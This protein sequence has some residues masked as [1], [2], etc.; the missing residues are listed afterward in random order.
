MRL[1][2]TAICLSTALLTGIVLATTFA[3]DGWSK[4]ERDT[5]ATLHLSQLPP[6]PA[7]PSNRVETMPR[8][9]ELGKRLFFDP[10]LSSNGKVSCA[11]CHDPKQ[12]FQDGKPVGQGVGTGIRRTMQVVGAGHSAFLF[13]DGRKDSL[14]AQAVGPL[15]D[16]AEHGGNRLAYARLMQQHYRSDYEAVFGALPDLQRLP[17]HA[18]PV[19]TPAQRAAW[20]SLDKRSQEDV[21]RVLANI[22]KAIAAYEKI[23]YF[24]ESRLDQYIDGVLKNDRQADQ[25]LTPSEKNGLRLFIGA[26]RCV[27]CH[28]GPLLSD[29]HFHNTGNAPHGPMPQILGRR[30]GVTTV[31]A[32]EFNCLGRFSDA[33]P[34]QC[35]ELNFLMA[36]GPALDGAFKTPSLRNV[37]LRPPYMHAGQM[38]TLSDVVRHYRAAPAAK[39]GKTELEPV[40]LTD[41][42]VQDI[43][44]FL[45][46]LSGPII[47]RATPLKLTP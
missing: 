46:T 41:Q 32:D 9:I 44:A 14:W 15:E 7:D 16:A 18:S 28:N 20:L 36:D 24:G 10:R 42:E 21:S 35:G 5:L 25:L 11:N 3:G 34:E 8:A 37:A 31:I 6:T 30:T 27:T 2:V 22:G 40:K 38:A 4:E 39:F 23:L 26:A 1:A 19:G 47:E 12:Q 29:Q 45:G 33:K 13:W 43:A 17:P